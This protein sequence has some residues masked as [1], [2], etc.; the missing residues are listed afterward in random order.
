MTPPEFYTAVD[1]GRA[2]DNNEDAVALDESL[3]LAVLADGMGGYNAGEVASDMATK[4]IQA[5]FGA[6]LRQHGAQASDTDVAQA[7]NTCVV[8][9]NRAIFDAGRTDPD[10][11]GMG[12]TLVVALLRDDRLL[13][14]HVG[15]SRAYRLRGGHLKQITRDH[16]VM[17]EYI[18]AGL[19][20]PEQAAASVRRNLV[21]RAVGVEQR[22]RLEHH[23]HEVEPGDIYLLCSDGLSDMLHSSVIARLLLQH[24][25]LAAAG[26]ALLD[27]ANEAGG[28]DNISLI[29]LR[30]GGAGAARP[31]WPFRR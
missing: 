19:L 4:R 12:T 16:S 27:A 10:C 17:Q 3:A 28:R 31:W 20:S 11:A 24:N 9:T 15:D 22:V 8:E 21:T 26:Q 29:L 13:V 14:G 23:L 5:D 7:L 30:A 2:R 1:V 6:W 18:D 25:S